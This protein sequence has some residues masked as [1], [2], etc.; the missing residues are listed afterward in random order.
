ME[1]RQLPDLRIVFFNVLGSNTESSPA[2]FSH[3]RSLDPDIFVIAERDA[4]EPV[5]D[6]IKTTYPFVSP[7]EKDGCAVLV[8]SKAKPL[9]FWQLKLSDAWQKRYAVAEFALDNGK[10]VFVAGSQISKPWLS[11]IFEPELARLEAQYKWFD[12]PVVAVGDFNATPWSYPMRTLLKGTGMR[13]VRWSPA[14]WP[15]GAGSLGLPID[16]VLVRG[17]ARVV[18]VRAFGN[19]LGSNHLGIVADILVR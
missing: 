10:S 9:R 17:G 18:N 19:D 1:M 16:Q 12:G 8:A 4:M 2:I 14:T 13:A 5:L 15:V 11:G 6:E 7:C 3:I